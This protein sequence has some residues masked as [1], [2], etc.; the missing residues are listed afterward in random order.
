MAYM[1]IPHVQHFAGRAN[2]TR[3][4]IFS[5][6]SVLEIVPLL[7]QAAATARYVQLILSFTHV[8]SAG[9]QLL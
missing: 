2:P 5:V 1:C 9:I 7:K 3:D 4:D 6:L 8:F